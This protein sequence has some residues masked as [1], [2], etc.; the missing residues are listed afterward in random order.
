MVIYRYRLP[1][2]L[3]SQVVEFNG[4]WEQWTEERPTWVPFK[5]PGRIHHRPT[6]VALMRK[7]FLL[8]PSLKTQNLFLV[9][10][11]VFS[12]ESIWINSHY[13]GKYSDLPLGYAVETNG[14]QAWD[15]PQGFLQPGS[16]VVQL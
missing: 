10:G 5:L 2:S 6:T 16:N 13:V 15:V 9:F 8:E 11:N 7:N 3:A 1:T 12:L 14:A 4:T